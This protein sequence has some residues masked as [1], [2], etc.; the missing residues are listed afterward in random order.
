MEPD[1]KNEHFYNTLEASLKAEAKTLLSAETLEKTLQNEK[2]KWIFARTA[3]IPAENYIGNNLTRY[4][5]GL[6]RAAQ[7]FPFLYHFLGFMMEFS[8]CLLLSEKLGV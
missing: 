2:Q 6:V 3:N 7:P 4:S 5:K 8:M 1:E